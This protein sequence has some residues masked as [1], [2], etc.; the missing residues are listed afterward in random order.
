MAENGHRRVHFEGVPEWQR[1]KPHNPLTSPAPSASTGSFGP[2]PAG[3]SLSAAES[4]EQLRK[5]EQDVRRRV[6]SLK[7]R[8]EAYQSQLQTVGRDLEL[9][10]AQ[11]LEQAKRDAAQLREGLLARADEQ[12]TLSRET[13][14]NELQKLEQ[15]MA[16]GW[17]ANVLGTSSDY[18]PTAPGVPVDFVRVGSIESA[19]DLRFAA[20]LPLVNHP[21]LYLDGGGGQADQLAVSLVTRLLAQTPI[22]HLAL[23]VFDPRLRGVLGGFT[24]LRTAHAPT[25]PQ[26]AADAR[27]FVERL[28]QALQTAVRNVETVRAEGCGTLTDLWRLRGVPEGTLNLIV[29][30]DYPYGVDQ[31]LQSQL[32]RLAS[33]GG[34][35]GTSLLIMGDPTLNPARDVNPA[36]LRERLVSLT[37]TTGGWRTPVYDFELVAD[38]APD[39]GCL[40]AIITAGVELSRSAQGPSVELTSLIA[41]DIA[42]PWQGSSAESLDAV[43]GV[44][45]RDP[46]TLSLRT[47]NP[48]HPNLLIGGAVGQGKS[49]LV[50]DIIYALAA[51]YRPDE[52]E[53]HLLDFKRGLEFKRFAPDI[54]GRNWLPHVRVLSLESNQAFGVAVLRHIDQQMASRSDAFKKAGAN[55]LNKYRE[56]TG[57][58]MPR[59][60]LAIDEF[61]ILFEGEDRYVEQAVELL[62]RLAKQGRAYGIHLLLASQTTSGVQG[63]AIK[64]ESIYAQFPLRL[65]LKNTVQESQA[66]LSQGNKAAAD[67]T[68]RGEVILNRNYGNDPEGSNV[69]GLAAFA[70]P[71]AMDELQRTLWQRDH[72]APPLV[73]VGS[74]HASWRPGADQPPSARA[75]QI[76]L[77]VG[78]PIEITDR[79]AW[80]TM[81]ADSDQCIAVVGPEVGLAASALNSMTRSGSL[82]LSSEP[83]SIVILDGLGAGEATWLDDLVVDLEDSRLNVQRLDRSQIADWLTGE[84]RSRLDSGPGEPMLIVGV[85][86][87]RA[88]EM[89]VSPTA[90]ASLPA[91]GLGF[92]FGITPE[93]SG[94]EM[95]RRLAREG[96][97]NG[98]YFVGWWMNLRTL[99]ADLGVAHDGVAQF[100]TAGL[101]RDDLRVI[102]GVNT[103]P[104][105][106]HPRVG[107]FDRN[108]D[109]GLRVVVPFEEHVKIGKGSL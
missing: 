45:G 69:R 95:L 15:S 7:G 13:I 109:G 80:L 83:A 40:Q 108:G 97:Q 6:A 70:N 61:H 88:R 5:A 54:D 35:A 16:P 32:L 93:P 51:R 11:R 8:V 57:Q 96:A 90:P 22:K 74:D 27:T 14:T 25:F 28:Q 58:P 89:D 76:D 19:A 77:L 92:G 49:N 30:L 36:E 48:P 86:L 23:Q 84:L 55:S 26:P 103:A 62:D 81:Q 37:A 4:A 29:V 3:L 107:V 68:Y 85:G 42:D 63:L 79:P 56:S 94:R 50:L 24:P 75:G 9:S 44:S 34:P 41:A 31:E 12:R 106:G 20:L 102:A 21:G 72:G 78:R 65:S 59:L 104:I 17:A 39:P 64:G 33:I 87:Q 38:P 91:D 73:F 100:V 101:G 46:L 18:P 53:L 99:E 105:D 10:D 66:I 1:A 71:A 47:E 60:V 82:Q 43:I 2:V 98:V 52:L 67:L